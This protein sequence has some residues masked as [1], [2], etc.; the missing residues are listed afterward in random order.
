MEDRS[1]TSSSSY[2]YESG[3]CDIERIDI[4]SVR[5]SQ[6]DESVRLDSE[7]GDSGVGTCE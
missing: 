1:L 2:R 4:A 3:V 5:Y 7:V 6:V